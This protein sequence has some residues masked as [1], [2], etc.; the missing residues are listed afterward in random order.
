MLL[1]KI[2]AYRFLLQKAYLN[3][4]IQYFLFSNKKCEKYQLKSENNVSDC[5]FSNY[6]YYQFI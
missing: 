4:F 6:L 2:Y 3:N 5:I 1:H